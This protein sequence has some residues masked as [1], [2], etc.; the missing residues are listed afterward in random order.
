M[1]ADTDGGQLDAY[2]VPLAGGSYTLVTPGTAGV[3]TPIFFPLTGSTFFSTGASFDAADVDAT[4]DVYEHRSDGSLHLVSGGTASVPASL[5]S[6]SPDG[7][8]VLFETNETLS[9]QDGDQGASDIYERTLGGA[10][11][12]V[13]G[14]TGPE[15][16]LMYTQ[17]A[18]HA[19]T[20]LTSEALVPDDTDGAL[21]L[22]LRRADGRL[23]L[24]TPGVANAGGLTGESFFVAPART[25]LTGP[26][27]PDTGDAN[28]QIDIYEVTDDGLRLVVPPVPGGTGGIGI[29]SADGSRI[30]VTTASPI[31]GTGD[32]DSVSDVY[33][34]EFAAPV[35][36][37]PP[38][39]AGSGRVGTRHTCTA[40]ISGEG[41]A[42]SFEWLRDGV[43]IPGQRSASYAPS[44]VDAGRDLACRATIAN[45]IGSDT[46]ISAARR[47]APVAV[48]SRLVGFPIRGTSLTCSGFVGASSGV[49]YRWRRGSQLVAGQVAR[50]YRLSS[51]DLGRRVTCSATATSGPASTAVTSSLAVPRRCVVPRVRGLTSAH[52][53][54]RLGNAGCRV[55]LWSVAGVGVGRGSAIGRPR[56]RCAAGERR[57]RDDSRPE[58]GG[59]TPR[60]PTTCGRTSGRGGSSRTAP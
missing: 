31:P 23:S 6:V 21:D 27:L 7:R 55:R 29:Q 10:V 25:T 8:A 15:P 9:A 18:S 16:A 32:G 1:P 5:I 4:T 20:F 41:T 59:R 24:L 45:A 56:P 60:D 2:T 19:V 49:T 35:L 22:Y 42:T 54:T 51:A 47:I 13:S 36:T 40:T 43:P 53:A 11:R 12:L 28:G 50:T 44:L 34:A 46:A 58:V 17:D 37:G 38:A 48:A 52:A 30:L 26:D 39:L 14:G 57:A 3:T 33:V